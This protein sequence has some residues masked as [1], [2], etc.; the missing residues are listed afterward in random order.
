MDIN[1]MITKFDKLLE[2]SNRLSARIKRDTDAL[3]KTKKELEQLKKDLLQSADLMA[4]ILGM[5]PEDV[6]NKLLQQV[7]M[8]PSIKVAPPPVSKKEEKKTPQIK[9]TVADQPPAAELESK[10]YDTKEHQDKSISAEP[11]GLKVDPFDTI[12]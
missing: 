12:L 5:N 11:N 10:T 3:Q 2:K 1:I 4:K 6:R 7:S 8:D 9:A